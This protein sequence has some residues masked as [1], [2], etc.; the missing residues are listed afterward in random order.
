MRS[1]HERKVY[2]LGG[3]GIFIAKIDSCKISKDAVFLG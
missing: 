2:L 3:I 1:T